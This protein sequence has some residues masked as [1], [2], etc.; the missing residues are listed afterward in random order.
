MDLAALKWQSSY[1]IYIKVWEGVSCTCFIRLPSNRRGRKTQRQ[2]NPPKT[3]NQDA[4][5]HSFCTQRFLPFFL[6]VVLSLLICHFGAPQSEPSRL[7]NCLRRRL[8]SQPSDPGYFPEHFLLLGNLRPCLQSC[9]ISWRHHRLWVTLW[10]VL[11]LLHCAVH[12]QYCTTWA[13]QVRFSFS[14]LFEQE[15]FSPPGSLI[16]C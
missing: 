4:R 8:S 16:W 7:L 13:G 12:K 2:K 10:S 11:P 6:F 5:F 9:R 1:F 3:Q 14:F 15:R